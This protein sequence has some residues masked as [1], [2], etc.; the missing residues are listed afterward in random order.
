MYIY[1]IMGTS[2]FPLRPHHQT[3]DKP[4]FSQNGSSVTALTLA[5]EED[6][7]VMLSELERWAPILGRLRKEQVGKLVALLDEKIERLMTWGLMGTEEQRF[8]I[9]DRLTKLQEGP[10]ATTNLD[11]AIEQQLN[12]LCNSKKLPDEDGETG[13]SAIDSDGEW[14]SNSGS[15]V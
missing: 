7:S 6:I 10:M 1:E 11:W 14:F 2:D 8:R 5:E 12:A 3:Q 13:D 4:S 9:L 15:E